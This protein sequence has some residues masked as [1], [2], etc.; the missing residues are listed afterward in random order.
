MY[1]WI[2]RLSGR[3]AGILVVPGLTRKSTAAGE[4]HLVAEAA[5]HLAE[6]N[7]HDLA[8]WRSFESGWNTMISSNRF[9]EFGLKT[10]SSRLD[11][12]LHLVEVRLR[13]GGSGAE[14]L[15]DMMSRAPTFDV[16]MTTVF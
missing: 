3:A 11:P 9:R 8:R 13:I 10:C 2:E 12:L 7:R 4:L 5:L 15:P 16:I 1:R 6:E 14:D